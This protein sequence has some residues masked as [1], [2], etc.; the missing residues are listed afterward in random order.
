MPSAQGA[1]I[2]KT[3]RSGKRATP[4]GHV[5]VFKTAVFKIHIPSRRKRVMLIN[6]MKRAPLAYERLL[7]RFMPDQAF[8]QTPFGL[9]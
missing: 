2:T 4:P 9:T 7:N 5:K 6:I 3:R 8:P 1:N